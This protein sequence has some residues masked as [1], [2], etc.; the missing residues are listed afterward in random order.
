MQVAWLQRSRTRRADRGVMRRHV[1]H[2]DKL[3]FGTR[4]LRSLSCSG[5][6]NSIA[7]ACVG[8]LQ[9]LRCAGS[10]ACIAKL[11]VLLSE[12]SSYLIC[13]GNERAAKSEHVGRACQALLHCALSEAGSGR[14]RHGQQG[15]Q[16]PPPRR[17]RRPKQHPFISVFYVHERTCHLESKSIL[18]RASKNTLLR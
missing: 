9:S 13:I 17:R 3:H 1:V 14:G 12:T 10:P 16:C 15:H 18:L 6:A 8:W 7:F 2:H 11:S 4:H 5:A